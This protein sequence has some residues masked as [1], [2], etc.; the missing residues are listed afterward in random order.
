MA[1]TE[2]ISPEILQNYS[3]DIELEEKLDSSDVEVAIPTP[4]PSAHHFPDGGRT[5]WL[6]VLGAWCAQF[7]SFGWLNTVGVFQDYYMQHQLKDYSSTTVSWIASV[8]TLVMFVGGLIVGRLFD[9]YGPRYILL[10]G[11]I[12]QVAAIMLLS[13]SST[14]GPIFFLQGILS[15][16]GMACV[17]NASVASVSSWFRRKRTLALG[18]MSSGSS[19]GGVLYPI[20]IRRMTVEST[21]G[22]TMRLCGFIVLFLLI[23]ANLFV[24]S[25][26]KP[27]GKWESIHPRIL[28]DQFKDSNYTILVSSFWMGFLGFML[29]FTYIVASSVFRGVSVDMANYIVSMMNGASIFGRILPAILA[30]KLGNYNMNILGMLGCGIVTLALWIPG[31]NEASCIAYGIVYGFFS[32][33]FVAL[34]PACCAQISPIREIGVRVGLMFFCLG[35]G[36]LVGVPVGGAILGDA[37]EIKQWDGMKGLAGASLFIGG[38]GLI[39]ARIKLVGPS[40]M[41]KC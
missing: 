32:G 16:V 17:F 9:C 24:R 27:K 2:E 30:D 8:Q 41:K 35:F 34:L 28:L 23:I 6:T 36:T 5:A 38:I 10:V 25:N 26:I 19:V 37:T 39:I 11:T 18:L 22:W 15:A 20:M 3:N 1:E 40:L 12:V 4:Q 33:T 14:F 7:C 31:S 13:I 21:F 29:P